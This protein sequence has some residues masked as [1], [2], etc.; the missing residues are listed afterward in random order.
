MDPRISGLAHSVPIVMTAVLAAWQP[1]MVEA[2]VF[3]PNSPAKSGYNLVFEDEFDGCA[4][5]TT[6]WSPTWA[7]GTGLSK[8]YPNDESVPANI[9][10]QNGVANFIVSK[11]PTP[12]GRPYAAAAATTKGRFSRTYGYFEMSA[13]MPKNA[14]GLWPSMF[15]LPEDSSWP[16]EI[17]VVEWLGIKPRSAFTAVHYGSAN[18]EL[19]REVPGQDFS[20]DFHRFGVLWTPSAVTWYIDGVEVFKA[21]SGIPSKP[22]YILL[23]NSTGGWANNVVDSTTVFPAVYSVRY[24]KA[25]SPPSTTA[26]Q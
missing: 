1:G 19:T 6:K 13:K 23:N 9:V 3:D 10:I 22:L 5:D 26:A 16:P 25:Y 15:M 24:V 18:Y 4:L 8:T 7:W 21:T 12:T 11:D 14:K 2:A 17:D 20:D